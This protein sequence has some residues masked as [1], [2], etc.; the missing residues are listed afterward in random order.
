MKYIGIY[1]N[2]GRVSLLAHTSVLWPDFEANRLAIEGLSRLFAF[3]RF[4]F[5]RFTF[6]WV[7]LAALAALSADGGKMWSSFSK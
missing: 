3:V 4:I 7:E 1:L 6:P 2:A 5:Y